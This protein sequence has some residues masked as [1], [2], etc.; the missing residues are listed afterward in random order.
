[1]I[2]NKIRFPLII[3]IRNRKEGKEGKKGM[4]RRGKERK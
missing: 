1:V 2:N 3:E 4:K